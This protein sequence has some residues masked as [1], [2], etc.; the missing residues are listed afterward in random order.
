MSLIIQHRGGPSRAQNLHT[1]ARAKGK[2]V[3]SLEN[4]LRRPPPRWVV[5]AR[6]GAGGLVPESALVG[7]QR[8]ERPLPERK[9]RG[10]CSLLCVCSA[11]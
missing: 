8:T 6:G 1:E 10:A 3:V 4:L 5:C 2:P 9:M 7:R 11:A